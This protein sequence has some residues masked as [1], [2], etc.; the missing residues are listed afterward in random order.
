MLFY[1]VGAVCI[2]FV[3]TFFFLIIYLPIHQF[4]FTD[5]IWKKI[6]IIIFI[7]CLFVI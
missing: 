4:V 1:G 7:T 5:L 2:F 6:I 3:I